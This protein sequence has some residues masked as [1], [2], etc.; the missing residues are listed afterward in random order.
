M[1]ARTISDSYTCGQS[2]K[3][4]GKV[5]GPVTLSTLTLLS[6]NWALFVAR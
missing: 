3:Q 6:N 5:L 4:Y 1:N 2:C